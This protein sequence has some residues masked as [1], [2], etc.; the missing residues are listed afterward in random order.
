MPMERLT[1]EDQ[2]MLWPDKL[3]PQEIGALALLD[4]S[5]LLEPGG[6]FRIEVVR[7]LIE[8]RLHLVPRFRQLLYIPHRGLGP[9]LWVDAPTFDLD[10]HLHVQ[11]LQA[12]ADEGRLLQAIEQ[13]RRHR[14]DR[15]RP[16]WEMWFLPGLPDNRIG[17]F[18]RMHHA[19]ADGIAGIAT[20]SVF[21]DGSPDASSSSEGSWTPSPWPTA[22]HLL[23]DNLRRKMNALG[24]GLATISRPAATLRN[25]R[26]AWALT[27]GL[28]TQRRALGTSL[29]RV[30]GP[31]RNLALFRSS[32]G[33]V[34]EIA[35]TNDATLNDVLLAV[36]AGGLRAL[37]RGRGEA[38][39]GLTM[40]TYVPVTLRQGA[41]DQARGN[42]IAQMVV[43]LPIGMS[44]PRQ[45]LRRIATES[46]K[47]KAQ[48]HPSLGTLLGSRVIRWAFLKVLDRQP[49]NV[50]TADLPG[51]RSPVY[52]AGARVLEA[53]PVLPLIA[54][55][56]IGVG[57]LS[58]TGQLNI[59][60]V[61]D[62]GAC[63]D[64][65]VFAEGVRTEL[66]LLESAVSSPASLEESRGGLQLDQT[67]Q[68]SADSAVDVLARSS[69]PVQG[70]TNTTIGGTS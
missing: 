37:L 57:A 32:L 47:K 56:P 40:P 1:A 15:S 31:D 38:V 43:S 19:I 21:L 23:A 10:D 69:P 54:K 58:Y 66:R 61:A 60:A 41:H 49:V 42:L 11:P 52:F 3:W 63:P 6:R 39:E 28:L 17:W 14:L 29:D 27:R 35:H 20:V 65:D 64:L 59:M 45:R 50:T 55:V 67:A 18:V 70:Q 5:D 12:P 46:A 51:P 44:D 8:S 53:F 2:L 68:G 36:T 30:V 34:T 26:G 22:G 33:A 16:L 7:D 48:S 4:G 62:K 24:R 25:L 13:V 9:P